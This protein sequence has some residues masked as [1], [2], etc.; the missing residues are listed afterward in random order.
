MAIA[1]VNPATGE[2]LR[3]FAP[4]TSTESET[5]LARAEI[6]FQQ[7]RRSTL[8]ELANPCSESPI[9]SKPRRNNSRAARCG[10]AHG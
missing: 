3:E 1:S 6:A 9:S 10:R 4:L 7:H 5:R 8:A 2:M